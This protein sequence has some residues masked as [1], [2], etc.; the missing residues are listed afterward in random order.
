M[1]LIFTCFLAISRQQSAAIRNS[2]V[3]TD[4]WS[5]FLP[6]SHT[7]VCHAKWRWKNVKRRNLISL[8]NKELL[9]HFS[10]RLCFVDN[11][12]SFFSWKVICDKVNKWFTWIY[13]IYRPF[14]ES[15]S[16]G[17]IQ[18]HFFPPHF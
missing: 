16:L 2:F 9:R 13:I 11:F 5:F 7:T 6:L 12:E 10:F 8:V 15:L 4:Y 1:S 17:A 3:T 18:G 14:D